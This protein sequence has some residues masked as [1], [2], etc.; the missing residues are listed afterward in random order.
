MSAVAAVITRAGHTAERVVS[1]YG[2]DLLV[3]TSHSGRMDASRL[4]FQVKGTE[5]VN[6]YRL[7]RGGFSVSVDLDHA[8]RWSRSADLVVVTL[9]DVQAEVGWYAL[10]GRQMDPREGLNLGQRQRALTFQ[11]DATLTP[12][13]VDLLAWQSRFDHYRLLILSVRNSELDHWL[14]G[15][16][17]PGRSERRV[18]VGL[19]LLL[20]LDL[21]RRRPADGGD[22]FPL[23]DR[24]VA[25]FT[26]HF[27]EESED[28]GL[29]AMVYGAAIKTLLGRVAE[30]GEG[31]GLP[32]ALIEDG[33]DTFVGAAGLLDLLDQEND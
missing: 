4:W 13:A 15:D 23:T 9:W 18:L 11:E 24:A 33:A 26:E 25:S 7:K 2:E 20:L 1:D 30:I 12:E 31:M 21:V 3:Q 22:E 6:R 14:E 19:D 17:H 27:K 8:L 5:H 16:P 28:E 32:T 29:K 10:P